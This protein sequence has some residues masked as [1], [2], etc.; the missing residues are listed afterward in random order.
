LALWSPD[1]DS[2]HSDP[3]KMQVHNITPLLYKTLYWF[4][5]HC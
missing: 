4:P 2:S 1:S 5:H 3:F